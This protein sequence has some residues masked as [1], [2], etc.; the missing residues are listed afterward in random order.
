MEHLFSPCTRSR[1]IE[2][3]FRGSERLIEGLEEL[4][5][6]VSI[7]EFL[8]AE[9]A[10]THADLYALLGNEDTVAWLTPHTAVFRANGLAKEFL[11]RAVNTT[12][13]RPYYRYSFNADGEQLYAMAPSSEALSEICDIVLRLLATSVAR[14]V[15]I[16][17]R[18]YEDVFTNAASLAYLMEQCQSLE[19]LT[20]VDLTIDENSCRAL[21]AYSRPDLEINLIRCNLTSAGTSAFAEI[22]AS[23]QGPTNLDYCNIDNFVLADGLRGNS[24]LKGLNPHFSNNLEV[25]SREVLAILGALRENKCL[26][27]LKL[28]YVL[29]ALSDKMW[30]AVCDSLQ[31][32]PT[33]QVLNL[34]RVGTAPS[35]PA[36][37][38]SRIQALVDMMK[39]NTSIHTIHLNSRLYSEHELFR[40]SVIP[41]L[42]TNR[43]RP[44]VRAIQKT[45]PMA[46]R[47]KV[48]GRGLLATRTDAN[49]IWMLL[50]GNPE[51]AF[52]S[53]PATTTPAPSVP[54]PT[55]AIV[56]VPA[57]A[58]VTATQTAASTTGVAAAAAAANIAT[59]STCQKRKVH[60]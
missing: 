24:R 8:S 13:D 1:L 54:T 5:L 36:L 28:R 43:L 46:Y 12:A 9:R 55:T 19:A 33:L 42:E 25:G 32:H 40:R 58:T 50:L 57:A 14:S 2:S 11:D 60:P 10:F 56:A 52:P 29:E 23:N 15:L 35:A 34:R 7:A 3:R 45:R 59:P 30:N 39:V 47:A 41:Y 51:V 6:D 21:G 48:L 31:T 4:N 38:E 18:A 16:I 22:L 44:R 17:R 27:D 37:L 49:S 20:L 26:V 53:T